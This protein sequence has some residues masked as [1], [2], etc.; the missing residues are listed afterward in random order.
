M[1]VH[2]HLQGYVVFKRGLQRAEQE[3]E[4]RGGVERPPDLGASVSGEPGLGDVRV[5][6]FVLIRDEL[7]LY[8]GGM[9]GIVAVP[10]EADAPVGLDFFGGRWTCLLRTTLPVALRWAIAR[11]APRASAKG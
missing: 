10:G 1:R 5:G 3:S 6:R 2:R 4:D 8:G 9:R 7:E 11:S